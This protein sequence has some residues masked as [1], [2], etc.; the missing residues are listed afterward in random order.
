M[1]TRNQRFKAALDRVG[2]ET[3]VMAL[4]SLTKVEAG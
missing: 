1:F 2:I 3:K 4:S